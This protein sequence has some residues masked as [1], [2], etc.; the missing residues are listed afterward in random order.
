MQSAKTVMKSCCHIAD[1]HDVCYTY[2][3]IEIAERS[4]QK[5]QQIGL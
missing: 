1:P 4:E 3:V 5:W 2:K